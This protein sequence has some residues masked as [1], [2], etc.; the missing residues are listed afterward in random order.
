MLGEK[1]A[2]RV[3]G[4]VLKRSNCQALELLLFSNDQALTRFA[5]N[6]IHQNV[7]ERDIN[8]IVR[9]FLGK[10]IGTAITNRLDETALDEALAHARYNAF[11]SPEDPHYPGLPEPAS[12]T[13]VLAYDQATADFSPKSRAEAVGK[14]CKL[15]SEKGLTASGSFSTGSS[16][17]IIANSL[18]LFAYH[19][20]TGADFQ[21]VVMSED[22]SGRAHASAWRVADLDPEALGREAVEKA[23]RGR[24]P[25]SIEAGEYSVVL[26]P[27]VTEDLLNMLNFHGMGAQSVLEGRSWMNE[28]MGQRAMSE[29]VSIWDD[30]LDPAGIPMPFDFEGVP[31]QRVDIVRQGIVEGP[32]Y[33]R[34]TAAKM[35]K[36]STGHALPPTMRGFGPIATNL[37]METGEASI[38]DMIR[39]T[40]KGL[41]ITRFWYTR[42][43]HPRDCV[44]TG[45]TRDG[46]FFIENGELAY[47]VKNMRFTQ[48]YVEALNQVEMIGKETRLLSSEFGGITVRVPALKLSRFIFTGTTV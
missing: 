5:N 24:N 8:L 41:Y 22:S 33:D 29:M 26:D 43:V 10:R 25:R 35:G 18:G 34:Y 9:C 15:A 42:L 3:I 21:T 4:K 12:Y 6:S 23:E 46:V 32:V 14:V 20:S 17:I 1:E 45:M 48:S 11:N 39:L 30:G 37:F 38:E 28:R 47:P 19:A 40:K 31:R 13:P 7:A 16:E 44:V 27:Y 2:R 36:T